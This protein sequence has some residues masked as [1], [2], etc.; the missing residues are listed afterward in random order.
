MLQ[1]I[2][3]VCLRS[4]AIFRFL[5]GLIN[6]LL[7]YVITHTETDTFSNAISVSSII[8]WNKI[9]N[10]GFADTIQQ[11]HRER[12][13]FTVPLAVDTFGCMFIFTYLM[14][15]YLHVFGNQSRKSLCTHY[16]KKIA[17]NGSAASFVLIVIQ[18]YKNFSSLD[19]K[20]T[21]DAAKQN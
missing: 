6:T 10:P 14:L 20:C 2:P 3:I 19:K 17:I 4:T 18:V 16:V 21:R 9:S 15:Q 8:S 1:N 13:R 7:R 12:D 11:G 5:R